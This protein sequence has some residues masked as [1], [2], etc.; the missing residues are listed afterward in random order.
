MATRLGKATDRE[1]LEAFQR[2]CDNF[3]N[4][5]P[6]NTRETQG[7]R[8]VRKSKLEKDNEAWFK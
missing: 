5:T 7:E 6:I 4:A 2:Y 1:Y 8:V 3:R